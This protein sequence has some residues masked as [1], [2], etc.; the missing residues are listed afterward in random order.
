ML[1]GIVFAL[2]QGLVQ[3]RITGQVLGVH[4]HIINPAAA[5]G[6][7]GQADEEGIAGTGDHFRHFSFHHQI[8]SQLQILGLG[9]A[10]SICQGHGS[11]ALSDVGFQSVLHSGGIGFQRG[12]QGRDKGV[13]LIVVIGIVQLVGTIRLL[14]TL[15]A[16]SQSQCVQEVCSRSFADAV[17]GLHMVKV[18]TVRRRPRKLDNIRDPKIGKLHILQGI[19]VEGIIHVLVIDAGR[20]VAGIPR[21][22]L[23]GVGQIYL[24]DGQ[25]AFGGGIGTGIFRLSCGNADGEAKKQRQGEDQGDH[26]GKLFH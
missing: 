22:V 20:H 8:Q 23:L 25:G 16:I 12:T 24:V 14:I 4:S 5:A 10:V 3:R 15:G 21:A 1:A 19:A 7:H 17:E 6:R 9:F 18:R 11:A 26:F 2:P 13:R